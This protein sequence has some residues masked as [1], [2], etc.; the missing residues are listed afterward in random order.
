MGI[1]SICMS[2]YDYVRAVWRPEEGVGSPGIGVQA[3]MSS[4]VGFENG[5]PLEKYPVLL[6]Y[7]PSLQTHNL[8]QSFC[9]VST[10]TNSY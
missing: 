3:V 9:S 1:L 7:E 2:M 6:P 4:H 10:L 8:G 5:N